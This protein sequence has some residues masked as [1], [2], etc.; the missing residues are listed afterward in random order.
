MAIET[1]SVTVGDVQFKGGA[2]NGD[3][4][5]QLREAET[6]FRH[7]AVGVAGVRPDL[8]PVISAAADELRAACIRIGIDRRMR[9]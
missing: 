4:L 7:A 9:R 1:Y 5:T 3:T 2:S 6:A 8:V